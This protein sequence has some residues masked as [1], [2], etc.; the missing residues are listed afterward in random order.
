MMH[1]AAFYQSVDP[2]GVFVQLAAPDDSQ[3][4]VKSPK[5]QVPA[6][7]Q[8]IAIAGLLDNTVAPELRL[9]APSLLLLSRHQVAPLNVAVAAAVAPMS[10]H[11]LQDLRNN[12]IILVPSE[13]LTVEILT[14]P[15]LPQIQSVLILFAD[16]A[17]TPIVGKM[18]TARASVANALVPGTWS[19]N[20]LTFDDQL[21]RGRYAI[22]GF[23][24]ESTTVIA[25]RI[26]IPQQAFRPGCMGSLTSS[27]IADSMFRSGELGS[28]GEFEDVDNLNV[29]TL[30]AAADA[31]AVQEYFVDLIQVRPGNA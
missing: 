16:K 27:D 26:N 4:T 10:P 8:I 19:A 7:N 9:V 22:V 1:L 15:A 25:S 30:A 18:F 24:C 13:Q 14:N 29:E 17:P 2:A 6:L 12:P 11:R 21:P 31:A 23:R 5:I 20:T 3:L 28:W